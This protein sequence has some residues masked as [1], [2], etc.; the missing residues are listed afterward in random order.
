MFL[1][2]QG[3]IDWTPS[4][5]IY[6][7][8]DRW[9]VFVELPGLTT[10]DIDLTVFAES[11]VIRGVKKPPAREFLAQKLEIYTG[12][13]HREITVP[14]RIDVERVSASMENGILTV[15]LPSVT[16]ESVR[17]PVDSEG[18]CGH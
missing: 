7:A 1:L 3:E 4:V 12:W 9:L 11:I 10:E 14:G 5:D 16:E 8:D 13:F 2:R 17:I 18:P 15:V 6:E